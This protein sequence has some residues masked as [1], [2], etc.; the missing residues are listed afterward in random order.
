M[1]AVADRHGARVALDDAPGGGLRV[2]VTFPR[3]VHPQP[4]GF[5]PGAH[6]SATLKVRLS[7]IPEASPQPPFRCGRLWRKF[8][9]SLRANKA[10]WAAAGIFTVG[11]V[12]GLT[13]PQ[14]IRSGVLSSTRSRRACSDSR[15]RSRCGRAH[16]ADHSAE[17]S[18][19]RCA[20]S[21]GGRRHLG[22]G[23]PEGCRSSGG[24]G[25]MP[26]PFGDDDDEQSVLPVLPRHA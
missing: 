9:M 24:S 25:R 22:H 10:V 19:D 1:K 5:A 20:E 4:P 15:F 3:G 14:L 16:S 8:R 23:R 18:R 17:L 12:T 7:L 2:T 21:G 11:A 6:R 13:A 26:S